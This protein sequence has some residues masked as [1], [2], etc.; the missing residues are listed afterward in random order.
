MPTIAHTSDWLVNVAF[1]LPFLGLFVW[2]FITTVRGR[3]QAA[4]EAR[5]APE[6]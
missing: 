3:R 4:R 1:V 5:D 6:A 2:L